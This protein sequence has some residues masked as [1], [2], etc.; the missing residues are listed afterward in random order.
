MLPAPRL[1]SVKKELAIRLQ[2]G[3]CTPI[4]FVFARPES[5][6]VKE[7]ILA[8]IAYYNERSGEAIHFF[9]A[10]YGAYW[11]K[12][13]VPDYQFVGQING[14]DWLFSPRLFN[15]FRRELTR[16]IDWRY[17]GE[18]DLVLVASELNGRTNTV[19][20][21]F[22]RGMSPNLESLKKSGVISSLSGFFEEIF[23]LAEEYLGN[24]PIEEL[25]K[26]LT[27]RIHASV[28]LEAAKTLLPT[29]LTPVAEATGRYKAV[30][31]R[32]LRKHP[33]DE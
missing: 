25:H 5:H 18:V 9:F 32:D 21:D 3:R 20:L 16:K 12:T 17:S 19:H 6:L 30:E 33:E 11:N 31:A 14:T 28:A 7:E 23:G 13:D 27:R 4:G 2:P 29:W 22:G 8:S 1:S 15:D 24:D 26:N 10:G